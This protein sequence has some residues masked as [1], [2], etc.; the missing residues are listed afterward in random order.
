M[1]LHV[2]Q[3]VLLQLFTARWSSQCGRC[4]AHKAI[5]FH[6][7]FCLNVLIIGLVM[8]KKKKMGWLWNKYVIILVQIAIKKEV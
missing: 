3:K 8:L 4:E 5:T 1:L 7:V 6:W 2:P